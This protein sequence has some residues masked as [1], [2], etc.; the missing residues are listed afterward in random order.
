[1]IE[2]SL[3]L[4][5]FSKEFGRQM[6]FISGP[7]QTGKTTLAK[8]FLKTIGCERLYYNWDERNIRDVYIEDNHFFSS[9]IFNTEIK[10]GKRYV[11]M[12]EI[13]K[14]RGWKNILKDFF[15]SYGDDNVFIV[16][17]SAK[18]DL[19]NK[20]GDSLAG[21]YF[22]FRLNPLCLRECIGFSKP[23]EPPDAALDLVRR[24][25]DSYDYHAKE[26]E[27]LLACSG[28][29]EPFIAQSTRFFNKWRQG[30]V[31]RIIR[32]DFRDIS[33]LHDIEKIAVLMRLLPER[34][35]SPLSINNLTKDLQ[36][37]FQTVSHY[38]QLMELGCLL[39]RIKPYSK[40]I[41]RGL[42]KETKAYFFD[43]TRP[44]TDGSRF[45]NFVA[46]QWKILIDLWTDWG[47]GDFELRYI[48]TRDA[49]ET[50]FLILRDNKPYLL[51]EAK[52]TAGPIEQHHLKHRE[53]IMPD[54]PYVQIVAQEGVADKKERNAFQIS[55]SRFFS[56]GKI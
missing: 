13:H 54:A 47:I 23:V 21:R 11:C 46:M 52:L 41:S 51:S 17:G 31:D 53:L 48:R 16:T 33:Q 32:E 10:G 19:F 35:G 27:S 29:P 2:R 8:T 26:F 42:S 30:Y 44:S 4:I 20:S 36:C 49:K 45:E 38:L 9:D 22:L 56:F 12:D 14:Y 55:A 40:K 25:L 34:I 5:A 43:W 50:D 15:D 6:R 1:M 24:S 37:S 39:F 18:L 7:R 28:Y 3:S